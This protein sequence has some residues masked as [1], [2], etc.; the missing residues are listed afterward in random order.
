MLLEQISVTGPLLLIGHFCFRNC[1]EKNALNNA[2]QDL[3]SE[4]SYTPAHI[5]LLEPKSKIWEDLDTTTK[6]SPLVKIIKYLFVFQQT[7]HQTIFSSY[8]LKPECRRRLKKQH[9]L[10]RLRQPRTPAMPPAII[11]RWQVG[12]YGHFEGFFEAI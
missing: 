3:Q 12:L 4:S 1:T 5:G 2:S 11:Y 7:K 8:A 6:A 10:L 9:A